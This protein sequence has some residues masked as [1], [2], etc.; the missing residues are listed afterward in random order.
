MYAISPKLIK[1]CRNKTDQRLAIFRGADRTALDRHQ[2][3]GNKRAQQRKLVGKFH[4]RRDRVQID[5]EIAHERGDD[6]GADTVCVTQRVAANRRQLA[7]FHA[8]AILPDIG[9]ILRITA[10]KLR[11]R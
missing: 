10:R 1:S 6:G 4:A 5:A 11:D 2:T 8:L 7:G 9:N 3:I